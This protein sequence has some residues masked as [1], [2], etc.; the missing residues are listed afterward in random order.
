[1]RLRALAVTALL[2][3]AV[4]DI[5]AA[6]TTLDRIKASGV[7]RIGYRADARPHSFLD[8]SGWPAGYVIDICNEVTADIGRALG[9]EKVR[10]E[11]VQVSGESRF[12][13]VRDG[14]L[15]LV[16]EASS[17]TMTRRAMVDFSLPIFVDGAGVLSRGTVTIVTFAD[18]ENMRVGVL[19]GT[20]TERTLRNA[21]KALGVDADIRV[22]DDHRRGAGMVAGGELDAYVADRSILAMLLAQQQEARGLQLS[23]RYFSYET[24]GLV[25]EKGD[26]AFRL[27]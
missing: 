11:F 22:V 9:M 15:D 4:C 26:S 20:T 25:L 17:M 27:L 6:A 19:G 14:R 3:W 1:M 7:V 2:A 18:L 13:S 21:L 24:Y 5:H 16:C 10:T 12:T 23:P 8:A